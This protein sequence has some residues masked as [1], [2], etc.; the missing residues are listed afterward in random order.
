MGN[1]WKKVNLL[2][3]TGVG[4]YQNRS[5][6]MHG[7]LY[8]SKWID[9]NLGKSYPKTFENDRK[10]FRNR[11]MNLQKSIV[12]ED[13]G[14]GWER[15]NPTADTSIYSFGRYPPTANIHYKWILRV[16]MCKINTCIQLW[17]AAFSYGLRLR[18]ATG[19]SVVINT[20]RPWHDATVSAQLTRYH[21]NIIW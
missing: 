15:E 7:H 8:N 2:S 6:R 16:S 11:Y 12:L 4:T 21:N 10:S 20:W 5:L 9:E 3:Q 18:S 14:D 17:T 1:Y 19:W 13:S